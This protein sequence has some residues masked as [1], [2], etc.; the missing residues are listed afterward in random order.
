VLLALVTLI[1]NVAGRV[2]ARFLCR[3]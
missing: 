3:T 2:R 1:N